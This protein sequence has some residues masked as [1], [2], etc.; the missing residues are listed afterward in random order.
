MESVGCGDFDP[1]AVGLGYVRMPRWGKEWSA[2]STFGRRMARCALE[3]GMER[4]NPIRGVAF[5]GA[6]VSNEEWSW[7][8][9]GDGMARCSAFRGEGRP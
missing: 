8:T 7:A 1:Q 4:L 6:A 3:R 5:S 2:A 9:P